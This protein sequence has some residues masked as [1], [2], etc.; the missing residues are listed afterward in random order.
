MRTTRFRKDHWEVLAEELDLRCSPGLLCPGDEE[1]FFWRGWPGR[2][3]MFG[4]AGN[5]SACLRN[6]IPQAAG[7]VDAEQAASVAQSER[8]RLEPGFGVYLRLAAGP[9][10]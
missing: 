4:A 7:R 1:F 6:R 8:A 2:E 9:S 3:K 5:A 10:H